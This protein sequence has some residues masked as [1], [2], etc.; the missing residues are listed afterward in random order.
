MPDNTCRECGGPVDEKNYRLGRYWNHIDKGD[1]VNHLQLEVERLR[2]DA[3]RL[4]K[5]QELMLDHRAP[6]LPQLATH[7][8]I[9]A[10]I[11][12]EADHE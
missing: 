1:C 6:G 12:A 10:A 3:A 5:L 9:R 4:D 11:D 8:N 7:G 2:A